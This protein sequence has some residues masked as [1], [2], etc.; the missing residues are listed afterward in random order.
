MIFRNVYTN[1]LTR[2]WYVLNGHG[3]VVALTDS[4]GRV[5]DSYQYD[6]GGVLTGSSESVPQHL[7]YAGYWYKDEKG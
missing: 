2:Y 6:S 7:R 5:V 4:T 1:V 3:D